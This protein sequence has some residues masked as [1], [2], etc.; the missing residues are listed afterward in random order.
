MRRGP[1]VLWVAAG[2]VVGGMIAGTFPAEPRWLWAI[3]SGAFGGVLGLA[4]GAMTRLRWHWALRTLAV[5]T[6]LGLGFLGLF[7]A[8]GYR[9]VTDPGQWQ[10][11]SP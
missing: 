9:Y 6:L 10:W 2:A 8:V 11:Y 3:G 1:E 7:L 4:A 5:T